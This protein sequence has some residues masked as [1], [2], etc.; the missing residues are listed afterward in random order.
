M[1][2]IVAVRLPPPDGRSGYADYRDPAVVPAQRKINAA[3]AAGRAPDPAWSEVVRRWLD[4]DVWVVPADQMST[5]NFALHFTIRHEG[6]L[7]G[8]AEL[9]ENLSPEMESIWRSFHKR[10]H[11]AGK[12]IGHYHE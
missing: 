9:P 12:D 5:G 7:A 3:R 1:P 2:H 8:L 11:G 4:G 10:L 6:E